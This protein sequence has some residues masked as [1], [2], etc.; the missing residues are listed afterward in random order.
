[1]VAPI[2]HLVA[3]APKITKSQTVVAVTV[4]ETTIITAKLMKIA[5]VVIAIVTNN[6]YKTSNFP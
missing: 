5:V 2:A 6:N 1:M 4:K 3:P